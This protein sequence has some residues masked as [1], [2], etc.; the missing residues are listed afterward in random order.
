MLAQ[1]T[2]ALESQ[3]EAMAGGLVIFWLFGLVFAVVFGLICMKVMGNKGYGKGIGF[4]VGF[5]GGLIGL[6]IA[7]V[8]PQKTQ[9]AQSYGYPQAQVA[10][11][12]YPP[13]QPPKS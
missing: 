1:V 9:P 8:L 6:I 3:Q 13:P 7:L 5:F 2:S 10:A 12:Q 11:T 4:V